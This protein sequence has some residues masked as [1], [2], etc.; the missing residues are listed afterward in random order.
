MKA[1][2]SHP[3]GVRGAS[4]LKAVGSEPI[5][6]SEGLDMPALE[7]LAADPPA[8]TDLQIGAPPQP[9][10]AVKLTLSSDGAPPSVRN[11]ATGG[12]ASEV[13]TLNEAADSSGW[14]IYAGATAVSVLW[15]LAPVMFAW[16]YRRD[17]VPFQNDAF[18][19]AV[20]ALL[21]LGPTA[22]VWIAAYVL[23]QGLRLAAETRRT[24]S[25]AENLVRPAA[26]AARGA[27]AAVESVRL[28]I[29]HATAAASEARAELLSLREVLAAESQRLIEAAQG[30][31]RMAGALTADLGAEREKMNA[32]AG[33]LDAQAAA[34]TDA[35]SRHAR[36]VA[37]ASDLAETQIREAEAALTARAADLA[38][39][40]GEASD[41]ARVAGED[42][43][44][45]VARLETA[46]LGVGDQVRLVEEGLTDQRAALVA[47]AHG[48]RA[49]HEAFAAEAESHLAQLN[50]VILQARS[51]AGDLSEKAAEN[52]EALQQL[53]AAA[54]EQL[55][56]M[57]EG[58]AQER[59]LL[60]TAAA[61]SLGAL[62]QV[63]L[64]ERQTLELQTREAVEQLAASAE[65]AARAATQQAEAAR[66]RIDQ[67]GEAAFDAGQK[68]D[69]A[70]DA[71]LNDARNLIEQSAQLVA[72]AGEKSTQRLSEG[73]SAARVTLTELERLLADVDARA[74]QLPAEAHAR[75]EAVRQSI[76]RGM[77]DLMASARKA[78]EETQ[79]I[80]AA[81]QDRVRRNYDMLS[82]AVRLM[83]VV[84]G[85]ASSPPAPRA[86][87]SRALPPERPAES[88]TTE[89][90]PPPRPVAPARIQPEPPAP[91]PDPAVSRSDAAGLRPRL[92]L[93][94]TAS[95]EE[96]KTV[97]EAA[98]GREPAE[99][100]E[101]SWTWK[102]LLSSMDEPPADDG[103]V[104]QML[105]GEIEAMGIDAGALLPRG[106][107]DEIAAALRNDA[108]EG[109]RPVVRRL[110][111][112]A[113]RRLS[114][115][116]MSDRAFRAQADRFTRRY[117]DLVV[118]A[119]ENG[120]GGTSLS[121]LLASDL[122]RAFLL[123]DAATSEAG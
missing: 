100:S 49:D 105:L 71:R 70:F 72:E 84:A 97:F 82:E 60:N 103:A 46:G 80:D 116:V 66:N 1:R 101:D 7:S 89:A 76:E 11:A 78:A 42:L 93:T 111:P 123:I 62:S 74:A 25:M 43:S 118:E 27:G 8:D 87:A 40:A 63:A 69:A 33:A 104:A 75:A 31:N 48:M 35:I 22:L 3:F 47:A 17:V 52:A 21:A 79:S 110:A 67:L 36:M 38:A 45:Q 19:L 50:E 39:A 10:D 37:E 102:E 14:R 96:F 121:S 64:R 106:R 98:N 73:L 55:R 117:Q 34:V 30:S 23:H 56:E 113:V 88:R 61:Q 41:A 9:D 115:R 77:D 122:G 20:F 53:I 107:I 81:F 94:P 114:R 99:P 4:P 85:A 54:A 65:Q 29:E 51:G 58:A 90:A 44:R 2:K 13:S 59:E 109:G 91:W 15:A 108:F 6:L 26:L 24:Q 95:D 28:E 32:M 18:A 12:A 5:V 16:G 68:A 92:R 112:A 120:G 57:A 86:T 83:G 119:L